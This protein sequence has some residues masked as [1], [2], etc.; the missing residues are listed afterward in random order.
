MK[1]TI[2]WFADGRKQPVPKH[3]ACTIMFTGIFDHLYSVVLTFPQETRTWAELELLVVKDLDIGDGIFYITEGS[4]VVA[5]AW[6]LPE[7]P[8]TLVRNIR[9]DGV[10]GWQTVENGAW[11]DVAKCPPSACVFL[12][13]EMINE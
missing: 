3:Y 2:K 5:E 8:V 6:T 13:T 9:R 4:R 7:S 11:V 12:K 1:I 10:L